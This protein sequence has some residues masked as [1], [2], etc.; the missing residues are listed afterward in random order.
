MGVGNQA[1]PMQSMVFFFTMIL[2]FIRFSMIHQLQ[3]QVMGVNLYLLYIFGIPTLLGILATGGLKRAYDRR[4]GLYWTLF[5]IWLLICIPFST[6]KGGSAPVVITYLRT[7]LIMLFVVAGGTVTWRDCRRL[8]GAIALAAV[9]SLAAARLFSNVD[10]NDRMQLTFGTVS[11]SNDYAGHLILVLPFLIWV[12][13]SGQKFFY[14]MSAVFLLAFGFYTVLAT[15]SRGALIAMTV[16]VI[17]SL[18]AANVR[19]KISIMLVV[20]VMLVL[21]LTMVSQR[22]LQRLTSFSDDNG[23]LAEA[24]ES[25]NS[26]KYLLEKSIQ[27]AVEHPLFGVGPGQFNVYEG[28]QSRKQG[29]LGMWH[30]THN[31]FTQVASEDGFPALIFF[32]AGIVSPMLLLNRVY[33]AAK[34]KPEFREMAATAFCL[35]LAMISF[36]AVI[37][38]LNFA[39]FFYLPAMAG[40][41]IAVSRAADEEFKK[42]ALAGSAPAAVQPAMPWQPQRIGPRRT[43]PAPFAPPVGPP[44]RLR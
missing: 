28:G 35:L 29:Q 31:S 21:G 10:S 7:D 5:G 41:A 38:F 16:G 20:G 18:I 39:Y 9:V 12:I 32:V 40:L 33:R 24:R 14:K 8:M 11:N 19:Q 2:V 3:T 25:S 44:S 6:W 34:G 4:P 23:S 30:D 1:N 37:F 15:A 36:S 22:T 43:A 27:Y 42:A 26:R 13:L 17:Y